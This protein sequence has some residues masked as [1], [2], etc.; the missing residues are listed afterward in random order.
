MIYFIIY[1]NKKD[2]DYKL[3]SNEIFDN[4]KKAEH[5]GKTSMKRGFVHKIIEFNKSNIDKYW[6][7]L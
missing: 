4:E 1:K 3:F 2:T 7:K 6:I 5:I